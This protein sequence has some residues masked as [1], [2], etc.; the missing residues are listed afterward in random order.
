MS[1]NNSCSRLGQGLGEL[2]ANL[3][4]VQLFFI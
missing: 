2:C 4:Q 3:P 1:D